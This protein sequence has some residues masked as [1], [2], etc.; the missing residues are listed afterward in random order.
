[1]RIIIWKAV[2]V[3]ANQGTPLQRL[4]KMRF[5]YGPSLWLDKFI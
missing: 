1:M 2:G 5:P 4:L 3:E